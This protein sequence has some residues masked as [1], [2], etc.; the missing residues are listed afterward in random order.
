MDSKH[1]CL[2]TFEDF[3]NS[4]FNY[5]TNANPNVKKF[6]K[7]QHCRYRSLIN[8]T[9]RVFT[10]INRTKHYTKHKYI[11]K[12]QLRR[13]YN[14][15]LDSNNRSLVLNF[16]KE[17]KGEIKPSLLNDFIK[18]IKNRQNLWGEI[19][20][21]SKLDKKKSKKISKD[22]FP[23]TKE[24]L[25]YD[26]ITF[27]DDKL[28][29]VNYFNDFKHYICSNFEK[30]YEGIY[31]LHYK[32][33]KGNFKANHVLN[34]KNLKIYKLIKNKI[35]SIY[36]EITR[37]SEVN[38]K[39]FIFSN[40][41]MPNKID[42]TLQNDNLKSGY[43]NLIYSSF[44]NLLL[45]LTDITSHPNF[46]KQCKY[47]E[48]YNLSYDS[49]FLDLGCGYGLPCFHTL[50]LIGCKVVG[51]E[52]MEERI[53]YAEYFK[54]TKLLKYYQNNNIF[55]RLNIESTINQIFC[56]NK[57][58]FKDEFK[59]SELIQRCNK[60]QYNLSKYLNLNDITFE[61]N[62]IFANKSLFFSSEKCFSHIYL[63]GKLFFIKENIDKYGKMFADLL[64]NSK[65]KVLITNLTENDIK[66]YKF[67]NLKFI[68]SFI[69]ISTNG[70]QRFQFSIFIKV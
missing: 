19:N 15:L 62:D 22:K 33:I 49:I 67:E 65:F 4:P 50:I 57:D 6:I 68:D 8:C 21:G 31:N 29:L 37:N 27:D 63:Y 9:A 38:C 30:K 56:T 1:I 53:K 54:N 55:Q 35:K 43:G 11:C 20:N 25:N 34:D 61:H 14:L 51:I 41:I 39:G 36:N 28:S 16:I 12:N 70:G 13:D 60:I 7:V 2:S 32:Q 17:N 64:N 47:S 44:T 24:C 45:F 58:L 52:L 48:E 23:L 66:Y 18:K 69:G 40:S 42:K 5:H 26:K 59:C 46:N 3:I 10:K